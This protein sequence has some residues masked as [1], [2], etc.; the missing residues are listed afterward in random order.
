ML[1]ELNKILTLINNFTRFSRKTL[2]KK[3]L[4]FLHLLK[5]VIVEKHLNQKKIKFDKIFLM[6]YS[7]LN[8][9]F[10]TLTI[11]RTITI[12]KTINYFEHI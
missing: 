10:D 5:K 8:Q 4:L 3:L 11:Y 6:K 1:Q 7:K 9:K 12:N 2:V